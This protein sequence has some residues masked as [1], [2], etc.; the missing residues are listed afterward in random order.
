[1]TWPQA[2]IPPAT[3]QVGSVSVQW[4]PCLLLEASPHDGP[5]PAQGVIAVRGNNN[6]AQRNI[7]ID[8]TGSSEDFIGMIAG[9]RDAA[10]VERLVID[11]SLLEGEPRLRLRLADDK[12]T[13]HLAG[14][15]DAARKSGMA[16]MIVGLVRHQGADAVELRELKGRIEIPIQLPADRLVPLLVAIVGTA[17]GELRLSQRR[18]DGALSAGYTIRRRKS[19]DH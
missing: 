11:A 2:L 12:L 13:Q 14:A 1:M 15:A 6:I 9:T 10:G 5:M 3:V 19:Q 17:N 18:G 8:G 16:S 4:H 7:H